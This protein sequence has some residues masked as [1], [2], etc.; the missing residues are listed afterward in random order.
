MLFKSLVFF[1]IFGSQLFAQEYINN[2]EIKNLLKKMEQVGSANSQMVDQ[3]QKE[4]DELQ[5]KVNLSNQK[6]TLENADNSI[7]NTKT[8]ISARIKSLENFYEATISFE[9]YIYSDSFSYQSICKDKNCMVFATVDSEIFN[10]KIEKL[11]EKIA[12]DKTEI[13]KGIRNIYPLE[14]Q[15]AI[16]KQAEQSSYSMQNSMN[17]MV[18]TSGITGEKKKYIE[19]KDGD[20]L[21]K[22]KITITP[23]YIKLTKK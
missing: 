5:K 16:I 4:I 2:D 9:D 11:N 18:S 13:T 8:N 12:S 7:G 17:S 6:R 1:V 10:Q 14:D 15:V 21:G 23:N 20:V 19:V 22:I 3:T